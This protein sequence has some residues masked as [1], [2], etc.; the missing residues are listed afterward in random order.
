ML[1]V[2]TAGEGATGPI[3]EVFTRH[4]VEVDQASGT[5]SEAVLRQV[6][7]G[8]GTVGI[9]AH[10]GVDEGRF[11]SALTDQLLAGTPVPVVVVRSGPS[12]RLDAM[13]GFSRVL[14]PVVGT[15]PNRL[16]QEIAFSAAAN[17]DAELVLAHVAPPLAAADD[18]APTGVAVATA[19]AAVV[20]GGAAGGE[21]AVLPEGAPAWSSSS[22]QPRRRSAQEELAWHVVAEAAGLAERLGAQPRSM[23]LH[24]ISPAAEIIRLI[25]ELEPDLVVLGAELRPGLPGLA[26]L[27]HFVEQVLAE[28]GCNVAVVAA[29]QTWLATHQG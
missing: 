20:A 17:T 12:P 29:P 4:R 24:G 22:G 28:V 16:A 11:F 21:Q 13:T 27:G 14:V 26:F 7:L 19:P 9:G 18:D 25:E 15:V 6:R 8:Y 1:G 23:V 3:S 5:P 10:E 2:G